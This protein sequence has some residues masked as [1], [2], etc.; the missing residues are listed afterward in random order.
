MQEPTGLWELVVAIEA[1]SI[2]WLLEH[3]LDSGSAPSQCSMLGTIMGEAREVDH[4]ELDGG[5]IHFPNGVEVARLQA[6]L[7][8][9]RSELQMGIDVL[10]LLN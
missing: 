7:K 1:C 5:P 8:Q 2:E 4:S 3:F 9:R 6:L 10:T